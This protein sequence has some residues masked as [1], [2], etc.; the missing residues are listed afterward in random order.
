[1][2]KLLLIASALLMAS[3]AMAENACIKDGYLIEL[4]YPKEKCPGELVKIK[5]IT[6]KL[7]QTICALKVVDWKGKAY[8][9]GW[10]CIGS[11]VDALKKSLEKEYIGLPTKWGDTTYP[12]NWGRP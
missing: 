12:S 4:L 6:K 1:M 5:K 7:N 11:D 10:S 9:T 2:K 3:V 8:V